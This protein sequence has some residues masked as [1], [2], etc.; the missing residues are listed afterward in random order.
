M[1]QRFFLSVPL[2]DD[3]HPAIDNQEE[4]IRLAALF[5]DDISRGVFNITELLGNAGQFIVA[6]PVEQ[7]NL[8][9][10]ANAR[11]SLGHNLILALN[12]ARDGLTQGGKQ[13]GQETGKGQRAWGRFKLSS[14]AAFLLS[15]CIRLK[16][17]LFLP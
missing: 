1:G 8:L 3:A 13:A 15:A 10:N 14:T 7:V 9:E 6:Q 2:A 4:T 16:P 12:P 5:K 11:F 17:S